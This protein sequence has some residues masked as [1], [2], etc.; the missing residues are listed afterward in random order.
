MKNRSLWKLGFMFQ[1]VLLV[2]LLTGTVYGESGGHLK[3]ITLEKQADGFKIIIATDAA[4]DDYGISAYLKPSR[5][6]I[7]IIGKWDYPG[8]TILKREND[9]IQ[10]IRVGEHKDKMR[11]VIDVKGN[12]VLNPIIDKLPQGLSLT[13]KDHLISPPSSAA[14]GIKTD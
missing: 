13:I 9:V 10:R 5:M 1:A 12:K 2:M 11:I 14:S 8:K 3:D 6:V 7:D 4:I